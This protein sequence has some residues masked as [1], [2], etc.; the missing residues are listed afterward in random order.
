MAMPTQHNPIRIML[1]DD[2]AVVRRGLATFLYAYED[3]ELVGEA[4]NGQEAILGADH[5]R[6]DIILMDLI[7]PVMDGPTAIA[8]IR[9]KHPEIQIIALTSFS[10]DHLV[11]AALKAGAISYMLKNVSADEL[12]Q[13]IRAAHSGRSMLAAE[14]KE[15]LVH[16]MSHQLAPGNDLTEREREILALMVQGL[17]NPAIAERLIVSRATVKFHVSNILSK[18]SVATRTEAVAMAIQN[19]LV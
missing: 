7:M 4:N 6:P 19:H 8:V 1:V 18:L 2:H 13:A 14:A 16:A 17:S 11:Q 12:V 5:Y 10:E 9:Q 15:A 3:L